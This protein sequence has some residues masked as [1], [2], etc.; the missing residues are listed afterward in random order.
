MKLIGIKT[1][2]NLQNYTNYQCINFNLLLG[3]ITKNVV[4]VH[5]GI[6]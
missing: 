1:P 2:A 3:L 6:K 5:N 4:I